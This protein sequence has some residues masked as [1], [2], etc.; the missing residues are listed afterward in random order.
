MEFY[1]YTESGSGNTIP[2]K[3]MLNKSNTQET[4]Y[5]EFVRDE[6]ESGRLRM[7]RDGF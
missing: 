6:F 4:D 7:S 5:D 3:K 2:N 1:F